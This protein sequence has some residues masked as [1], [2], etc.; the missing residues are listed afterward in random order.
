MTGKK[1]KVIEIKMPI[2]SSSNYYALLEQGDKDLKLQNYQDAA[3]S[4]NKAH[5]LRPE[6]F[7]RKDWRK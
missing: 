5:A 3:L 4:F 2:D 1:I 6:E 7:H